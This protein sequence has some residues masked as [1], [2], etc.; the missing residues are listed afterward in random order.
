MK[1]RTA[2]EYAWSRSSSEASRSR[3]CTKAS[4]S[5]LS[6]DEVIAPPVRKRPLVADD[7]TAASRRFTSH[8]SWRGRLRRGHRHLLDASSRH[9][10]DQASPALEGNV[11][12]RPVH[13]NDGAVTEPDKKV[14]VRDAP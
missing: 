9:S 13:G 7:W 5:A 3:H 10:G 12:P 11:V 4:R 14:N 8:Q 6:G 1:L 2:C